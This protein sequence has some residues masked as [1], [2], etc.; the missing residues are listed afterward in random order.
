MRLLP[1]RSGIANSFSFSTWTKP[2]GSP[3]GEQSSPSGPL[4]AM[5][6]KG[7]ASISLR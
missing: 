5:A 6:T 1:G 3:L 2:A 7:A 4:V